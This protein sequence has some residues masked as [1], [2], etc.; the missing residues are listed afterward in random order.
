MTPFSRIEFHMRQR[1]RSILFGMLAASVIFMTSGC[2][3][4][5]V[6]IYD[7]PKAKDSRRPQPAA[8]A[9]VT[10]ADILW[11]VSEDWEVLASTAFSKGNYRFDSGDQQVVEIS[12]SSFPGTAGGRL[13]NVNRWLGQVGRDPIDAAQLMRLV[14]RGTTGRQEFVRVDLE[15]EDQDP[16]APRI[17]AVILE[18]GG[19]TW[20]FKMTGPSAALE[21][22]IEA[23]DEMISGLLF[24]TPTPKSAAELEEGDPGASIAFEAPDGWTESQGSVLRVA[25][26]RISKEGHPPAD[27][28]LTTFRGDTGGLVPNVNRWRAQVGLS[29]WT[30]QDV[31]E[32]IMVLNTGE[33]VFQIF[34]LKAQNAHERESSSDSILVAILSY[35]GNSWFFKLRGD[36]LL[37]E[38]QRAKFESLLRSVSFDG[39]TPAEEQ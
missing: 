36:A 9:Q 37:L 12:V 10:D 28:S 33:H 34:D 23:F 7:L 2:K 24:D 16:S 14:E 6:K 13:S 3:E 22:Q 19:Q 8:N 17:Y 1:K 35:K 20:F 30:E 29:S 11:R 39:Q 31:N 5:K 38:T 32:H 15:S 27:F 25:S 26:Y 4:A 18:Y 21:T